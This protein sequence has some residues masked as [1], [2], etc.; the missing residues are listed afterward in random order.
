MMHSIAGRSWLKA[1]AF[2][3]AASGVFALACDN[4]PPPPPQAAVASQLGPTS[5]PPGMVAC[6]LA[7]QPV[8]SVQNSDCQSVN[9]SGLACV[10]N[11]DSKESIQTGQDAVSVSCT[12]AAAGS[13]FSV[14]AKVEVGAQPTNGAGSSGNITI[15]GNFIPPDT[16]TCTK[17]ASG[18]LT[19]PAGFNTR[20]DDMGTPLSV[21]FVRSDVGSF[22]G[23]SC[24]AYYT[25]ERTSVGSTPSGAFNPLMGVAAGR[26]WAT[27]VCPA[28][29]PPA[30]TQGH[31]SCD[32][33]AT[34]KLEN[35]DPGT[36]NN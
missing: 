11:P 9:P 5:T 32:A 10:G 17:D 29:A 24:A 22:T 28:S 4:P 13:S 23:Q 6:G 21:T 8:I 27:I 12:I 30:G 20:A 2:P 3:L 14:V 1:L 19:C 36:S 18:R 7:A 34:I 33:L 16:S 31:G 15:R 25:N 26:L 35:C